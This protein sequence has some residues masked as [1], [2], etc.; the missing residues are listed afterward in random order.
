[1]GSSV[2]RRGL[3]Q[4]HAHCPPSEEQRGSFTSHKMVSREFAAPLVRDGDKPSKWIA[5]VYPT[6]NP[7]L[8][9]PR[10]NTIPCGYN[11]ARGCI[12]PVWESRITGGNCGRFRSEERR[13]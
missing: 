4:L 10:C 6:S 1:M 8:P 12:T 5:S 3:Q 11:D 9:Q 13:V 2:V 7:E